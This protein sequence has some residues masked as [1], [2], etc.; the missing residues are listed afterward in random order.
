MARSEEQAARKAA[1]G[2]G[3]IASALWNGVEIARKGRLSERRETP[4]DVVHRGPHHRVRHYHPHDAPDAEHGEPVV[5]VPPL[6]LSADLWDIAPDASSVTTLGQMGADPY[7]VDFGSPEEEE[8]G[9]ERTLSDHVVAVSAA[10]DEVHRKTGRPVHLMGYSQGGMFAYQAAAYRQSES[11]A[12]IVT[13]GSGVDLHG[14]LPSNVPTDLLIR[15]LEGAGEIQNAL[16]PDGVP[17]WATRLGFQLLDPVKTV[18][19]R[20][21]FLATLSDREAIEEREGVRRFMETEGW[22]AFPGPALADLLRQ[23]VAQNRLL[24]G[25]L[26]IDDRAVTLA[27]ITCPILA[28]TG[29]TDAIAPPETVRAIHE[30]A[31]RAAC[32]EVGVDAGHFGLVV[33]STSSRVVWPAVDEWLSWCRNEGGLPEEAERLDERIELD[34]ERGPFERL[35]DAGALSFELGA[36][37]VT[38]AARGFGLRL[39]QLERLVDIVRPQAGR[40]D[41]LARIRSRTRVS[42]GRALSERAEDAPDD[43]FFLFDGRAYP[44]SAA[45]ERVDNIV[46]GFVELG[47]RHGDHVG[48]LMQTRPS[49]VASVVALSRMGAIAVLL[50]PDLP[51]EDQFGVARVDHLLSDPENAETARAAY[52]RDVF[53]LGGGG[54]PRTLADGL[55][56]MEAIDPDPVA[57]PDWYAPN[58]GRAGE[59]AAI[60]IAGEGGRLRANRVTNRRWATSAYGTASACALTRQDTVYCRT[61]IHHAT[62]LLVCVGGALT[63]GARL[64]MASEFGPVLDPTSF[65]RDA[66]RYGVNVVFYTGAMLRAIVNAT[67]DP[68]ERNHAIRLVAGSGMPKTLWQRVRERFPSVDVVEFFAPSEGNAVLVNLR[69]KKVGS[70]GRPLPGAGEIA[71]APWDPDH[72]RIEV[73]ASGLA[74]ECRRGRV[75]LLLERV[76]PE[77]GELDLRPLRSVFE[78]NDAWLDSRDLVRVD[79]DGDHWLVDRRA[80]V[81]NTRGGRVLTR[82]IEER[83]CEQLR[84][85]DLAAAYGV[86]AEDEGFEDVVVAIELRP[87]HKL[88]VAEIESVLERVFRTSQMPRYLRFVEALPLTEG[89]R[90]RKRTLRAQGLGLDR[91][92]ETVWSRASADAPFE[93]VEMEEGA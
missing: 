55:V 6:M 53:V 66:R 21:Q 93:P 34:R 54:E 87:D 81:V 28:F 82:E 31:P 79:A 51:L 83:L 92:G 76:E 67:E 58:P 74:A 63:S 65:W 17:S 16:M 80:D 91:P 19:Q 1:V 85:I 60:L 22:T 64:A 59:L 35:R 61:P 46:R 10:V 33:G 84:A 73:D 52:G 50:R 24:Q 47:V 88:E 42:P 77:R 30:A 48:V 14:G 57:L 32:F 62:G 3:G 18:R 26:V 29:A 39:G 90:V 9:L 72:D 11:L 13:F 49:A 68:Y 71:V 27:D 45:N 37:I 4:Y 36:G 40:L 86:P 41:Q 25:G 75:G 78:A 5:L 2:L 8:G 23:L 20:I 56:D 89:H 12:S 43:T 7:V 38:G 69:G 15:A 70:I 44:Y